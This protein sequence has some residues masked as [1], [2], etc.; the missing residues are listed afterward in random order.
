MIFGNIPI[1]VIESPV[2]DLHVDV[3]LEEGD[4]EL[5]ESRYHS[6]SCA[7]CKVP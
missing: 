7:T 1:D 5:H 6:S 4:Q 3:A 2:A